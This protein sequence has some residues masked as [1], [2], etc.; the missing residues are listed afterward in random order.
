M[1][2][3]ASLLDSITDDV[4]LARVAD[5][6][7]AGRR[8][9]AD[10]VRHLAE[11][12]RRRLYLREACPSMH[13]YATVRL[14]LSDAEAYLRITAARLSRR[15]PLVLDM[16]AD[17]RVH[18]SAVAKLAPHLGD[19]NA[20]TLLARAAYRSKREIELLVAELAP[21]P[22]VPSLV[23]R[24]PTPPSTRANLG[25]V[26]LVADGAAP[27]AGRNVVDG[28]SPA[29]GRNVPIAS[30]AAPVIVSSGT[31]A[32]VTAMPP[33]G[34]AAIMAPLAPS[35]YK[36]QFTASSELHDK[37][38]R[39]RSL[40]RHQIPDGDLGAVFDRAM[41]LLVRELERARFA[42]TKTPRKA[43][44]EVDPTPSS[45]RIPDPIKREVWTRDAE[46]C[47]YRD[48][49]GRRCPAR[50]RLEFHHL[51]PFGKGGDHS[52]SNLALRCTAHNALQADLDFGAAFMAARRHGSRARERQATFGVGLRPRAA[53]SQATGG[54]WPRAAVAAST[55]QPRSATG[56]SPP[57]HAAP[58]AR[59]P[60]AGGWA[61]QPR[62]AC[63]ASPSPRPRP[64]PVLGPVTS[65][66]GHEL[67]TLCARA[68]AERLSIAF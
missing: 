8:V 18:L 4:L 20:E 49:T 7:G 61:S 15:F 23:R 30:P 47:T 51:V 29:A 25:A 65:S 17:G 14:H 67:H 10:L 59:S 21:R 68:R 45:R 32:A 31:P 19:D 56:A 36:V 54:P 9:E 24:L 3:R 35:R 42:A 64:R 40:L 11:V 60:R 12:D 16:L 22:D 55:P 28:V 13:V 53:A 39:A 44:H 5:L 48:R 37:I 66:R 1:K 63:L 43:I 33:P 41:T 34:A 52:P 6:V 2:A 27:A 38:A 26:P 50:E 58:A 62:V 57:A 46:Q